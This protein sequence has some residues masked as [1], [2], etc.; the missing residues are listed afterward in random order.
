MA[1]AGGG[2]GI[3]PFSSSEIDLTCQSTRI[4]RFGCCR[5]LERAA[6]RRTCLPRPLV[7]DEALDEFGAGL[8]VAV[9]TLLVVVDPLHHSSSRQSGQRQ[10]REIGVVDRLLVASRDWA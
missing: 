2:T 10:V 7:I 1:G 3:V 6:Q 4:V 8:A 5:T 9:K